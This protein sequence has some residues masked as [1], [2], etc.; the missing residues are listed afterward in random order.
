MSS[1]HISERLW[2]GRL[3]LIGLVLLVCVQVTACHYAGEPYP[4]LFMPDFRGRPERDGMVAVRVLEVTANGRTYSANELFPG[5]LGVKS[6]YLSTA[7]QPGKPLDREDRLL[8]R[9]LPN[10]GA[11]WIRRS[12]GI[13]APGVQDWLRLRLVELSGGPVH[14]VN[15]RWVE[16]RR[17][18]GGSTSS[19]IVESW[20]LTF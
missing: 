2:P 19:E 12:Q 20:T 15:I 3:A 14:S 4:G 5:S 9:V 6:G 7:L 1:R 11:A 10:L 8:F 17:S 13:D 16:N 18:F